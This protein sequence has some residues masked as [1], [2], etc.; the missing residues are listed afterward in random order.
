[1]VGGVKYTQSS[2]PL[3]ALLAEIKRNS[4]NRWQDMRV[5]RV[6]PADRFAKYLATPYPCERSLGTH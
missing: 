6:T 3:Q 2:P 5:T 1:V 4:S